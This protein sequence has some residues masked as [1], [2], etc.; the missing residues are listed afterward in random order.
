MVTSASPFMPLF[1]TVCSSHFI[2]SVKFTVTSVSLP[3]SSADDTMTNPSSASVVYDLH[4]TTLSL[5]ILLILPS[6]I[7][8]FVSFGMASSCVGFFISVSLDVVSS[9]ISVFGSCVGFSSPFWTNSSKL[10]TTTSGC[11]SFPLHPVIL[12]KE[13]THNK[14][15]AFNFII[16]LTSKPFIL[17]A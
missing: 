15:T 5:P 16:Y 17:P 1:L 8:I 11:S 12:N 13:H 10:S 14:I 3:L 9:C 6:N 7:S 4:T 2:S